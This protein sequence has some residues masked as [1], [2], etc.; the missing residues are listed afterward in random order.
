MIIIHLQALR[1]HLKIVT[2]GYITKVEKRQR[3][4]LAQAE[5]NALVC[6]VRVIGCWR[7]LAGRRDSWD[8]CV[9]KDWLILAF[10]KGNFWRV[11]FDRSISKGHFQ[12]VIFKESFS[13]S[14]FQ[15]V[16]F[17]KFCWVDTVFG[18][19]HIE[20]HVYGRYL[21]PLISAENCNQY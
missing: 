16:I 12:K 9:R 18:K 10:S 2:S 3:N 17:D 19:H 14:H 15:R 6:D 4:Y 11:I 21:S 8:A 13:K 7:D 5:K 1:A 20:S